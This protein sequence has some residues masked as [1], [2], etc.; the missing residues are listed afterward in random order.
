MLACQ[1]DGTTAEM[2]ARINKIL[3]GR[4]TWS[5][6]MRYGD[7][8]VGIRLTRKFDLDNTWSINVSIV[9]ANLVSLEGVEVLLCD[10]ACQL[11]DIEPLRKSDRR[12]SELWCLFKGVPFNEESFKLVLKQ[13]EQT[14]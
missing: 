2:V 4:T 3:G 1:P 13:P 14:S 11:I 10:G 6:P 5:F 9:C 7:D 8:L 12:M